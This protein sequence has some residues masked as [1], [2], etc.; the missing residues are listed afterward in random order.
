MKTLFSRYG[1]D[2][3]LG[4]FW[5]QMIAVLLL[6]GGTARA[7]PAR[8]VALGDSLVHGYGLDQDQGFVPQ[9][10]SWLDAQGLDSVILNAGLSGDTT[11][12]GLARLDWALADGADALIVSLGGNDI[13][14]AIDPSMARENLSAILD[15]AE[16]DGLPVLLIGIVVP[17]NYGTSY[18][19]AFRAIYPELS[20]EYGTLL[21]PDFLHVFTKQQDRAAVT[22]KWFQPDGLHPNAQGVSKIVA[23][24]G[25]LV[26]QLVDLAAK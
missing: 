15:R 9:L 22:L 2:A 7:E 24:M 26:A 14:R 21:Y 10:Q 18:Q 8:I 20:Q 17:P 19:E 1:M 13:L 4:K 3:G 11:A 25:P 12:G 23:D 5:V 6:A 16:A